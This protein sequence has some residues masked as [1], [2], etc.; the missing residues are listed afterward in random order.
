MVATG[1]DGEKLLSCVVRHYGEEFLFIDLPVLV[2][3]EFVDHGLPKACVRGGPM[4]G[5]KYNAQFL[6]L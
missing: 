4:R 5:G 1:E 2:K 6:V 3:V